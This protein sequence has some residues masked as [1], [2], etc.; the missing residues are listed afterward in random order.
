MDVIYERCCGLDVHKK[1]VVACVVVPDEQKGSVSKEIRTF[2]SM[3]D[4]LLKLS[5]WLLENRVKQVALESTGVY[6]KPVWNLLEGNF[7]LF[8]FNP[9]HIKTVPGRK[10]DV[11]DCEWIAD[12][13]RHG[14]LR[15]SFVPDR[16]QRELRELTRY[17]TALIQERSAEVSRLQKTL[18]GANIKLGVVASDIMG[19]SGRDI[20][21]HLLMGQTDSK[22]LA[23]LARGRLRDKIVPLQ[24][25]LAGC[26]AAHQRFLVAEQLAHIDSL[27]GSLERL[28][29]EV[30]ERMRPF[31][32]ELE[33]L[34]T[35]PGI[36][37]RTAELLIA[38]IGID[39]SRFADAEHLASWA[40]M[41][42]GNQE[43]A[44]KRK[45]SRIRRGSPWLR[46][47]LVEAANGASHTKSGYLSAQFHRLAARRGHKKAIVALGHTILVIAYHILKEHETYQELGGN[48]FDERNKQRVKHRLIDRLEKLG[49]K[50]SL[51][52]VAA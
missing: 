35:I 49:Y 6:W 25:A 28:S 1:T 27:D 26:F 52:P 4:D 21:E 37:R 50:V 16:A 43:S 17:R 44:G 34:E 36:S 39:M 48:Y 12:L 14:L 46:S 11:K 19:R 10:S 41:V 13:L 47:A 51:Q 8:L 33:R 38:E 15:A 2:S 31:L 24:R 30:A 40:G 42:P 29:A 18:E 45:G 3:T 9:Q 20:L 32:D 23:E 7:E 5:D 22:E